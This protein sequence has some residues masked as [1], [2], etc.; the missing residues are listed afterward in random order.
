[1]PPLRVQ[2][3][4]PLPPAQVEYLFPKE[5]GVFRV[6]SLPFLRGR[7]EGLPPGVEGLL[8]TG[9]L[10]GWDG[11]GRPLGLALPGVLRE[12][13]AAGAIPPPSATLVFLLG[14]LVPGGR[15]GEGGDARPVWEAFRER[16]GAGLLE[17]VVEAHGLSDELHVASLLGVHSQARR[18]KRRAQAPPP[19]RAPLGSG[20]GWEA[21]RRAPGLP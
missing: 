18:L 15:R 6:A 4:D 10:Q 12:L 16:A 9:D 17:E 13:A 1:M 8:F 19:P 5:G 20:S 3:L 14:D 7:V 21:Q 11:E 2:D